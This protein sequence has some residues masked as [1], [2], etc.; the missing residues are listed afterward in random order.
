MC[1]MAVVLLETELTSAWLLILAIF[2]Q[3][4]VG[5]PFAMLTFIHDNY[6]NIDSNRKRNIEGGTKEGR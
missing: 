5:Y 1:L 6:R 4:E 2:S 3:A